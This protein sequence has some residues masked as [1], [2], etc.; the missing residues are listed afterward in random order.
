MPYSTARTE[1][2]NAF[3]IDDTFRV[4]CCENDIIIHSGD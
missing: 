3:I 2:K 1:A 4:G